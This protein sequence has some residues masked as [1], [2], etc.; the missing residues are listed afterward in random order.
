MAVVEESPPASPQPVAE[1][2]DLL[3]EPIGIELTNVVRVH[4]MGEVAVTALRGVSLS[5]APGEFVAI[6][7]PSGCGKST[8]LSLMGGLDRPTE[9]KIVAGGREISS[10]RDRQLA[11]YRLQHV[12]TIFQS[13]NLIP[14]LSALDNVGL[15]MTLG[16]V[17]TTER[18]DRSRLLL[19]KVGLKDR[20]TFRPTRLSGGEQ[21]RVSVA[22]ALSNRPGLILADEP[23]GN[24]DEEAGQGVLQLVKEMHGLGATVVMV[25]HDP[26]VAAVAGRT[27]RMRN[28]NNVE[29]PGGAGHAKEPPAP[30][31]RLPGQAGLQ[32]P[33][34][35][36]AHAPPPQP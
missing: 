14:T 29:D 19:E 12:G 23:T 22:R 24:L 15:P 26:D 16:G 31:A 8:L 18:R 35:G 32:T 36:A 13:F 25:T 9:G 33:R 10:M 5:I 17:P 28:G 21:Q 3:G 30:K 34:I 6:M 27:V 7:G 1:P 2:T 11:D 4:R 20:I